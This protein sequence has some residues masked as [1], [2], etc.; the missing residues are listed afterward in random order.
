[1][2]FKT[3]QLKDQ[4]HLL[5]PLRREVRINLIDELATDLFINAENKCEKIRIGE[6]VYSP[7]IDKA[8][9]T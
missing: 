3:H 9:K 4:W 1:M 7:E 8:G 2:P 5:T 6:V